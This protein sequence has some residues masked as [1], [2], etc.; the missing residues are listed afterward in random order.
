MLVDDEPD[1]L[2][3]SMRALRPDGYEVL[4]AGTGEAALAMLRTRAVSIIVSDFSMP[5]MHGAQFLA[6]AAVL[7]PDTLRIIVSGQT[8]NRAM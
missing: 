8:M 1:V 7:Q 2:I 3:L 6:Q 5:G 4:T